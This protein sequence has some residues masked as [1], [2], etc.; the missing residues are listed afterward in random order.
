MNIWYGLSG[1]PCET[2]EEQFWPLDGGR[3]LIL[4]TTRLPMRLSH[5][6]NCSLREPASFVK[7]GLWGKLDC[8][9][10]QG[11]AIGKNLHLA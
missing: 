2:M 8:E 7:K 11:Q 10:F 6:A 3:A 1:S 4:V 9:I 5:H